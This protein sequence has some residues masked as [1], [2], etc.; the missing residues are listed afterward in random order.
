MDATAVS[1]LDEDTVYALVRDDTT[2]SAASK[3]QYLG[4]LQYLVNTCGR[5]MA[6][7]LCHPEECVECVLADRRRRSKR[8]TGDNDVADDVVLPAQTL[9]AYCCAV[10]SAFNRMSRDQRRAVGPDALRGW[11]AIMERASSVIHKKYSNNEASETQRSNFVPWE[12]LIARRDQLGADPRTYCGRTHLLLS[13]LT[14]LPPMRTSDLGSLRLLRRCDVD[15]GNY[16]ADDLKSSNHVIMEDDAPQAVLTVNEYKTANHYRRLEAEIREKRRERRRKKREFFLDDEDE[17]KMR[18]AEEDDAA[19]EERPLNMPPD[20]AASR[21]GPLPEPLV[22]LLAHSLAECPREWVF[23]N[24]SGG[25]FV[26]NSFNKMVSRDL[27]AA[28]EGK[29]NV[30]VN[31]VRHAA[32]TWLDKHHRRDTKT[33]QYF[34][35]WMMHSQSMQYDYVLR[36]NMEDSGR[37]ADAIAEAEDEAEDEAVDEAEDEAV[38]VA[39]VATEGKKKTLRRTMSF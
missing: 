16:D 13:F 19:D 12:E 5:G 36:K 17:E 4:K 30:T 26:L 3:T 31:L 20:R 10:S 24:S 7:L 39:D 9:R 28:F 2:I 33:R 35:K 23:V 29:K 1:L 32:A 34:R 15:A 22:A 25:P 11:R 8:H 6:W 21:S 14:Y 37:V 18:I 38:D 27:T